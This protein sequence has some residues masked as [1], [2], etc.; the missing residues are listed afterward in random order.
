MTKDANP[1]RIGSRIK[2]RRACEPP[3]PDDGRRFLV[4]RIWPRGV[5]KAELRLDGWRRD[6]APNDD[7][8]RWFGHDPARW[9]E[10]AARY[11]QELAAH[12][13]ALAPLLDAA[14][15]GPITLVYGARDERH[16]QAVVLKAVLDAAL[17]A[18]HDAT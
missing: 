13:D 9:D 4:D 7:V 8:R 14:R 11:R 2:L 16:N 18:P 15:N 3:R 12:P 5:T 1:A 17:A 6:L 10:F